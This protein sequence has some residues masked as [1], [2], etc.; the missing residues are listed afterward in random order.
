MRLIA[1]RH[2]LFNEVWENTGNKT[3][4]VVKSVFKDSDDPRRAKPVKVAKKDWADVIN[5]DAGTPYYEALEYTPIEKLVNTLQANGIKIAEVTP[6]DETTYTL[7]FEN[8]DQGTLSRAD[9]IICDVVGENYHWDRS[10]NGDRLNSC[11]VE[12]KDEY[13]DESIEKHNT[14]NPDLFDGESLKPEVADKIEEIAFKFKENIEADGVKLDIKDIYLVGS[15]ASYNYTKD[16]DVDIHIIANE[17]FDC[18]ENHLPIIYNAYK[19][20]FNDKYDIKI[21][22]YDVEVYVEDE[23]KITNV[24]NG[25]YSVLQNKW[26]KKPDKDIIPN[27]NTNN[28]RFEKEF[29]RWEDRYFDLISKHSTIKEIDSFIDS[30]YEMRQDSIQKDGEYSIGNLI[31]KEFRNLGYLDNLKDIKTKE[32]D[33]EL[34]LSNYKGFEDEDT[35]EDLDEAVFKMKRA[36]KEKED[37]S[38]NAHDITGLLELDN[39]EYVDYTSSDDVDYYYKVLKSVEDAEKFNYHSDYWGSADSYQEDVVGLME[40]LENYI[41]KKVKITFDDH[42]PLIGTLVGLAIDKQYND[43]SHCYVVIDED[44]EE[45]LDE[46]LNESYGE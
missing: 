14:L 29:S 22:G 28:D 32:E 12:F 5:G 40:N 24:S 34:S 7:A 44:T 26:I 21:N 30:L 11:H 18:D 15:N 39:G 20:L 46:N 43:L 27:V 1:T 13:L 4:F 3:T 2:E 6:E 42:E 25:I 16:S 23:R 37:S 36:L 19:S 9:N 8:P 38:E 35:E 17:D 41:G 45:K 33:S 10:S 31:F